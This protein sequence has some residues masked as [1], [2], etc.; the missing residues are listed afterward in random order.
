M[1]NELILVLNC[2]SSSLKFAIINPM[3][4]KKIL[5][6]IIESLS[7]LHPC[8]KWTK[9]NVKYKK[10]INYSISHNQAL[11]YVF[12]K[13]FK[14]ESDLLQSIIGVGHRVVHGGEKI[15]NSVI[16]TDNVLSQI[17]HAS[18]F[19]PLHNPINILGIQAAMNIFPSL[20]KKNVAVFDTAFHQT[21][22]ETSY[23]YA[24]PYNFYKN[25]N[26]RRY[27]A[28]GIS[29]NYITLKSAKI[30]NK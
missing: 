9:N 1:L 11:H 3:N 28:H 7:S 25:H 18:I 16:I 30:L 22:S 23:L 17:T 8:I 27:G 15:I 12:E 4:N 21:M 5:F 20:S 26:I 29:H 13:I 19:A 6:G 14:I 2:G 10:I 24:I